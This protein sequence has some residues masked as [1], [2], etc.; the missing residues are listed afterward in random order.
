MM[1]LVLNGCRTQA[2]RT[3]DSP[4]PLKEGAYR[5]ETRAWQDSTYHYVRDSVV[6]YAGMGNGERGSVETT[7]PAPSLSSPGTRTPPSAVSS[8]RTAYPWVLPA[9]EG[10]RVPGNVLGGIEHWHTEYRDR[11]VVKTDTVY[12]DREVVVQ[13]PP[14]RYVP[15]FYKY[16]TIAGVLAVLLL[17]LRIVWRIFIARRH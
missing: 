10:A 2:L 14:E 4:N 12:Q 1:C 16:G 15:A 13:L 9:G 7:R 5:A 17:I 11:V 6:V 3:S 8:E